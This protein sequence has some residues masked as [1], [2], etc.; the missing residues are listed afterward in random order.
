MMGHMITP[1]KD[2]DPAAERLEP[3]DV[4]LGAVMSFPRSLVAKRCMR[5][6]VVDVNP[7][8]SGVGPE[9]DR[10]VGRV[11]SHSDAFAKR[12][13][14]CLHSCIAMLLVRVGGFLLDA[15]LQQDGLN[16]ASPQW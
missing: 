16:S 1:S 3:G 7:V 10:H 13:N 9:F 5:K 4:G 12:A 8:D 2:S 6:M 11:E 15:V 14:H